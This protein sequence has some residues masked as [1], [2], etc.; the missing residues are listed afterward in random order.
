MVCIMGLPQKLICKL[1]GLRKKMSLSASESHLMPRVQTIPLLL[2]PYY[3]HK[4]PIHNS[5]ATAPTGNIE[6]QNN[7]PLHIHTTHET[8]RKRVKTS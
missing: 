3:L 8:S 6:E 7:R 2:V 5:P 4:T 1:Q